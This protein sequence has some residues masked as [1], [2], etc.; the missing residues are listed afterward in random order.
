M[1][2]PVSNTPLLLEQVTQY[3]LLDKTVPIL[4]A[5]VLET[6]TLGELFLP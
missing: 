1:D 2:R 5:S 4:L 6:K 3:W